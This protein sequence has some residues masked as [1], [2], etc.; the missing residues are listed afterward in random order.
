[1]ITLSERSR[2][3]NTNMEFLTKKLK[4][5]PKPDLQHRVEYLQSVKDDWERRLVEDIQIAGTPVR[6]SSSS[7]LDEALRREN[8]YPDRGA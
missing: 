3:G 8:M 6:V 1:M 2:V 7:P 4:T 5:G